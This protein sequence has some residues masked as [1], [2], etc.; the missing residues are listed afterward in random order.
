MNAGGD[1]PGLILSANTDGEIEKAF[2]TMVQ[3]HIGALAV[4]TFL[5]LRIFACHS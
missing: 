5:S 4:G 1:L 2:E 3:Q